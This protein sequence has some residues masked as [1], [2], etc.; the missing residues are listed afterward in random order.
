MSLLFFSL[1]AALGLV[2]IPAWVFAVECCAALLPLRRRPLEPSA[3]RPTLAVL[4]PAHNEQQAI[5]AT[6]QAV[7]AQLEASDRLIVIA[8]NCSD[9]TSQQAQQAG[10]EVWTRQDEQLRG[11][12]YAIR[13]ALQRLHSQPPDV[14]VCIDADCLPATGCIDTIARLAAQSQRPVQAAYLMHAPEEG[15]VQ[16]LSAVSSLAVLVKNY[17][18]PRGLQRLGLPCLLTGSGMAFPWRRLTQVPHPDA[19]LVEDMRYAVDLAIAGA[20]PLPAMEV[21]VRSVLPSHKGAFLS[22]R[23]RWEHGHLATIVAECPRLLGAWLRSGRPGLLALALDTAVPPLSLLLLVLGL[24]SF[25]AAGV[26]LL[27][28]SWWPLSVALA[29]LVA[30]AV[31][32]AAV[33]SHFGRETLPAAQLREIPRY[34]ATKLPLYGTFVTAR[35]RVWVRTDRAE[36]IPGASGGQPH[37]GRTAEGVR[38]DAKSGAESAAHESAA[39][40]SAAHESAAH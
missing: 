20:A 6:V 8:D 37:V 38:G 15:Q 18:R 33:W 4:I 25:F 27:F 29:P 34:V 12:G 30:V 5:A 28:A 10:A 1:V 26:S 3:P 7:A 36:P 14:V 13:F 22:Q 24:A 40:E 39:H 21:V 31:A 19:D 32:L 11:K 17:V 23:K 2:T 9:Q 35:Q 16:A